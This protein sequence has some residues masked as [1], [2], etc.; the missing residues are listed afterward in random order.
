MNEEKIY[1]TEYISIR[2]ATIITGMHPQ[3][4]RKLGDSKKI[5][6]YKTPS[7]INIIKY[8]NKSHND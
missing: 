8:C 7:G 6:C 2:E 4:L 3:T 5:I 1:S